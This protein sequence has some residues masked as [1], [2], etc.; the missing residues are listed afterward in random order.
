MI[1]LLLMITN[2]D[3]HNSNI[4]NDYKGDRGRDQRHRGA[5]QGTQGLLTNK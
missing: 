3:T 2:N 5:G 4:R 1:I